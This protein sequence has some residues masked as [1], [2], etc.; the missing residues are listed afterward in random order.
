M[1]TGI[2][3]IIPT[4]NRSETLE[5]TLRSVFAANDP[6]EEIIIVDQS[7]N[8]WVGKR[9]Q[10]LCAKY[11][12]KYIYLCEPSLTKARNVAAAQASNEL[13]LFMDDDVDVRANTFDNVRSLFTDEFLAMAGGLDKTAEFHNSKLGY[14]F[15][16]SSYKRRKFGHVTAGMYGRFPIVCERQTPSEWCM[17]FF[18]LVR[19]SLMEKWNIRFDERLLFYAYAEDLDFTYGY[20]LKAKSEGLRCIMSSDLIVDH[21]GSTEW[22]TAQRKTV[23]MRYAHRHYINHKYFGRSLKR[24]FALRWCDLGDFFYFIRN[25]EDRGSWFF[26]QRYLARH[27]RDICS[28]KF[29]YELF[30]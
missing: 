14:M 7:T 6:P 16:K 24:R 27:Y 21:R 11:K 9:I 3:M 23:V 12:L 18:F 20:Y 4:Y 28:G 15:F 2:S 19:R 26:A 5:Q 8:V 22:R 10:D 13:L 29:H 25:K 17:G 1:N 30:M